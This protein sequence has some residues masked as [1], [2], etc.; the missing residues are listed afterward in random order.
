MSVYACSDL[1]GMMVFYD[2]IKEY[3]NPEDTIYFLGDAG[4]RGPQSWET[5]D[6]ILNDPQFIFIKGNHEDMLEKAL[7]CYLN[8]GDEEVVWS[9]DFNLLVQNGG[10]KTFL[11]ARKSGRVGELIR[12]LRDLPTLKVYTNK[13]GEEIY[14]CHAGFT[15]WEDENGELEIPGKVDLIWDRNHY[16]DKSINFW[17]DN[18]IIVH[19]HTPIHYLLE[20]LEIPKEEYEGGALWYADGRKCDIDTGAVFAK[21]AVLIDL[22]TWEEKIFTI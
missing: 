16:L 17:H 21:Q 8:F 22:D 18:I 20:E 3:V 5:L 2:A 1:H 9:D 10:S 12:K 15:P 4:D 14:L 19:G 11:G 13:Q 6:T 7:F